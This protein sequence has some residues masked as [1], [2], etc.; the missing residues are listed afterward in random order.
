MSGLNTVVISM[1]E[2]YRGEVFLV[3]VS[4][5]VV[6]REVHSY[7]IYSTFANFR[8]LEP[9]S[10]DTSVKED[11]RGWGGDNETKRRRFVTRKRA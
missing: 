2:T 9:I 7:T 6:S 3:F 4:T 5:G 11:A 10:E 1:H 8:N